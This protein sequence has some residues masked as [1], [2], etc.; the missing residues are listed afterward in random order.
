M[1]AKV[2]NTTLYGGKPIPSWQTKE[3]SLPG[4]QN[5][6][7]VAESL[8]DKKK[9]EWGFLMSPSGLT[10]QYSVDVQMNKTM[11]GF[12]IS[13]NGSN[14]GN[15][16]ITGY[17]L[18]TLVAPERLRFIDFYNNYLVDTQN[19]YMEYLTK[20]KIY[21]MVEGNYYLGIIQSVN[22]SKNAS[23]QFLY[24]YSISLMFYKVTSAYSITSSS[25]SASQ[26][27]KQMG[28][29]IASGKNL[30]SKSTSVSATL[31]RSVGDI[32]NG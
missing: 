2:E 23:Q 24:Q 29:D 25:M 14:M 15:L 3:F 21:I 26:M 22:M 19:N 8:A 32:L 7:I 17:F 16:T 28:L 12:L 30:T 9:Y 31:S 4:Y 6:R 18:D 5:C 13:R 11:A 27:K 10:I 1:A 20:Y